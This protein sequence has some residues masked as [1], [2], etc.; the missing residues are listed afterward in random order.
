MV[1]SDF[2]SGGRHYE[3][4][5]RDYEGYKRD[6]EQ[7]VQFQ[8]DFAQ[9]ALKAGV[10]VNGGA[11]VAL[12]TFLGHDKAVI[13]GEWLWWAFFAFAV[14]LACSLFAYVGAFMSQ[15]DLMN[16]SAHQ[17]SA[18]RNA[19]GLLPENPEQAKTEDK[20]RKRGERFVWLSVALAVVS[21]IGF[22]GGAGFALA[23]LAR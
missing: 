10:I 23:G 17:A 1:D 19:M 18:S 22:V 14:G 16:L 12:F 20:Y 4:N 15:S 8:H 2:E 7:R 13:S 6:E 3:T 5:R 21:L 11:I 9:S